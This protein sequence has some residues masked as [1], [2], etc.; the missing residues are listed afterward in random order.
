MLATGVKT[1]VGIKIEGP[2]LVILQKIGENIET[3]LKKVSGT[4]SVYA[5]HAIG[6]RYVNIDINRKAAARFGLNISNI[7]D[8]VRTAIGGMNISQTI[9]NLER[10][11]INLRYPQYDRDS[12]AKLKMLP[13]V[14]PTGAQIP[15]VDV[16]KVYIA[17]GPR[18]KK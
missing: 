18:D 5:E 11:P 2:Q 8:V 10:Y 9:E 14:T 6:G 3:I 16:A 12:I 4:A 15:L 7:D 13:I 17:D 1:P